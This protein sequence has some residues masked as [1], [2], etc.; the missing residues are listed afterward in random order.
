[1]SFNDQSPADFL[2]RFKKKF[3][4]ILCSIHLTTLTRFF[5]RKKKEHPFDESKKESRSNL[6]N[7]EDD[8]IVG[9]EIINRTRQINAK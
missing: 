1:M 4:Y 7:Q 6:F 3:H 2:F 8:Q 9:F 5:K